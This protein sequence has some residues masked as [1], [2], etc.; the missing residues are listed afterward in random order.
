LKIIG[1]TR[2]QGRARSRAAAAMAATVAA[3]AA[4]LAFAGS[5]AYASGGTG[6]G[7]PHATGCDASAYSLSTA[8]MPGEVLTMRVGGVIAGYAYLRYSAG[9]QTEWVKVTYN[10]GF[11]PMPSVWVQNT[12]GTNLYSSDLAPWQGTTWTWQLPGMRYRAACG[13]VQMYYTNGIGNYGVY[14]GWFYLGCA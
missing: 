1:V 5:P 12:S 3:G 4:V 11:L 13:G 14:A 6:A 10:S 2:H 8:Q 7:D 9:C